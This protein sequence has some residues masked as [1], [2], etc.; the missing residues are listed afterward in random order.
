MH[1]NT[2][3]LRR[4]ARSRS[5]DALQRASIALSRLESSDREINF[6]TVA[7]EARVSTAWLYNH[8]KLR[9]RIMQLRRSQA[10]GSSAGS[11][12][13]DREGLS[14]RSIIATLR[15]RIK[16]LEQKNQELTEL[17]EHAYGVI[18]QATIGHSDSSPG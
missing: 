6:R 16:T 8:L 5:Q 12:S 10:H 1:R 4:S 3:G 18:A 13:L 17:L 11:E 2:E 7:A 15:M 14:R 9:A